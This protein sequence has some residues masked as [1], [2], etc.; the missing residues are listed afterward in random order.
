MTTC[1][2]FIS[3]LLRGR[4]DKPE[5][6][7]REFPPIHSFSRPLVIRTLQITLRTTSLLLEFYIQVHN[8]KRIVRLQRTFDPASAHSLLVLVR[9]A[10]LAG[11]P[12]ETGSSRT[13][14]PQSRHTCRFLTLF[15]HIFP[16]ERVAVPC[17]EL[18]RLVS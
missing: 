15:V 9:V 11:R 18:A 16:E 1:Y 8:A 6:C 12:Y 13:S 17:W 10:H 3:V 14:P 2:A 5:K 7:L 4:Q